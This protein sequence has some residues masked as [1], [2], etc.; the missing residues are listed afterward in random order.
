MARN[1]QPWFPLLWPVAHVTKAVVTPDDSE[2]STNSATGFLD[3][4]GHI[5]S[6]FASA[7]SFSF[8]YVAIY[9]LYDGDDYPAFGAGG[10][11]I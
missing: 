5:T 8:A 1:V 6:L 10:F 4:I 2:P 11:T 7:R 3:V 9:W